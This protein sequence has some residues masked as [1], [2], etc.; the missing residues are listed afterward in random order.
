MYRYMYLMYDASRIA[1]ILFINFMFLIIKAQMTYN[2][3]M[4]NFCGFKFKLIY[5]K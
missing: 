2:L 4:E 3:L 1:K 5:T